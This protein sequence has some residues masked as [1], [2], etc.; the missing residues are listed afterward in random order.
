MNDYRNSPTFKFCA[1]VFP[2]WSQKS[3]YKVFLSFSLNTK[4]TRMR[5]HKLIKAFKTSKAYF[6]AMKM[7]CMSKV[8]INYF[9]N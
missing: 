6:P 8:R 1:D 3:F 2:A 7:N 9:R 4:M 5:E